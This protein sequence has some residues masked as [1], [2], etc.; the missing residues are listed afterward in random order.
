MLEASIHTWRKSLKLIKTRK[1]I[2]SKIKSAKLSKVWRF[3]LLFL[4]VR[5]E[6]GFEEADW[7]GFYMN[8]IS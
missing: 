8:S 1:R 6:G 3:F 7:R 4:S 2:A 5:L